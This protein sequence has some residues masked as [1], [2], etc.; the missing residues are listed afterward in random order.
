[1]L[2]GFLEEG[3]EGEDLYDAY[4]LS[5]NSLLSFYSIG[6][7]KSSTDKLAIQGLPAFTEEQRDI[8]IGIEV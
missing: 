6:D 1:M 8:P 2:I 3:E 4:K 7:A 5:G